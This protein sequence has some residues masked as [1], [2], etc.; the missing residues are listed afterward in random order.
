MPSLLPFFAGPHVA[1]IALGALLLE[2]VVLL[3]YHRR[4][5]SG[6]RPADLAMGLVPGACLL[7]ALRFALAGAGGA[8]LSFFLSAAFL[9]HLADTRRRWRA[10]ND[11][12]RPVHP[13][14][15]ASPRSWV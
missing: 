14:G 12:K 4:T 11:Q 15:A 5:G 1:D 9:T 2:G 10:N 8:V 7:L 3:E 13:R 6:V